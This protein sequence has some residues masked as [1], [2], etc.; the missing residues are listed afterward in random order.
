MLGGGVGPRL[1]LRDDPP[2]FGP[3]LFDGDRAVGANSHFDLAAAT[4]AFDDVGFPPAWAD[5]NS[6][7]QQ[8]VVPVDNIGRFRLYGIDKTFSESRHIAAPECAPAPTC[9]GTIWV[10]LGGKFALS[11]A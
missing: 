1:G 5:A 7:A 9:L 2:R 10:P 11:A 8:L 3:R 4:P 6:K